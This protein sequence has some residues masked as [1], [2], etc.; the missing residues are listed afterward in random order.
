M[1]RHQSV[2]LKE[3]VDALIT[4]ADGVYVDGTFGRGGHSR[5]ILERLSPEGRLLVIDKDPEAIV[6][7]RAMQEQDARLQF[8]H[9]SFADLHQMVAER[10]GDVRLSGVLLDLGVSSPQLDD[11]TRGFSFMKD[12]PLD[13]RMNTERGQS[14]AEWLH[15]AAEEEIANVIYEY[16]EEKFSRRMAKAIVKARAQ[17]PITS[18]LQLAEI[19]KEANPA[20]EKHK[21]P[22]TRAFQGIRI[23][24]NNEL[25][26]LRK[27]LDESL[28]LLEIGG[29]MVI[30]SFHSLEDRVVKQFIQKQVRGDDFPPGLPV[31]QDQLNPRLKAIGKAAKVTAG[32]LDDNIR[33]RSA[34]MRVAEK[35]A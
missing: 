4:R 31:T 11:A 21:H 35:I 14:A 10:F 13:M 22:A 12:G 34:I 9:G 16:G 33:A 20:W 18:T 26:D 8:G 27:A 2:L 5:E 1:Y 15:S 19:V 25:Q 24:I 7:A 17:A 6:V 29:R 30:I 32:Q 23:F 28:E 3:A